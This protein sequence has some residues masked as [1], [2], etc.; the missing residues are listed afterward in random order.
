[1]QKKRKVLL[2]VG[3]LLMTFFFSF[4]LLNPSITGFIIYE[5]Q[6]DGSTINDTYLREQF[7]NNNFGTAEDLR[8]GNTS[9][10]TN[11]NTLI[12]DSNIST[13]DSE[14]TIVSAKLQI[15]ITDSFGNSNITLRA[16]QATS[17]WTES[18]A[19]WNNKTDSSTWT[20]PGGDYTTELGSVEITNQTGLYYNI[21]ITQAVREWVNTT[22]PNYGII[23]A[24][25]NTIAGNY[26]YF[27]SSEGTTPNQRPK[28]IIE[29]TQNAKP[30]I[31]NIST[32]STQ[33]SPIQIG[34]TILFTVNWTDLESNQAQIFIC[35]SSNITTAGCQDTTYCST[36]MEGTGPSSCVYK[37]L[38]TDN[39]TTTY[40]AATCD[41]S[42]CST[43]SQDTFYVNH[44]PTVSITQPDG[45]ETINQSQGNYTISFTVIDPNSDKLT[46]NI[47]YG[48]TQN[49]TTNTIVLN[50]NLTSTCTDA[51]SD[52]A[53]ENTCS[54]EWDS[55]NIHGTYFLTIGLNDSYTITNDSSSTSFE[56]RSLIDTTA[57]QITSQSIDSDIYSGESIQITADITESYLDTA[58]AKVNTTPQTNITLTNST[59][60]SY[61]GTWTATSPG[62]YQFKVYANDTIGNLNDSMSWQIFSIREPVATAQNEYAPSIALPYHTIKVTGELNATDSLSSVYA[63][64]NTPSGF[65]FLSDYPQN[66]LIGDFTASQIKNATWFLSVP[67]TE[68][69]Y[70]LNITY[71]D[72]YSNSWDSSNTQIQVTSAVGGGYLISS[73]G[74][75]EVETSYDYLI[76]GYFTQSGTRVAADSV[77]L[78][79]YDSTDSL[80]VGPASMSNPETGVYNYTYTVPGAPNEGQWQTIINAT[81]GSTSY[82]TNHFW[83]V[84]GGPFD[85]RD[86]TVL[87]SS[88]SNLNI[89]FVAENTGGANKDLIMTWNLS[90]VDNDSLLDSGGE[91][92]MVESA[93][94]KTWYINP[95]TAYVGQVKVTILGYYSGTEKA[96]A[97]HTFSTT[98]GGD[99]EYCGDTTCNNGETCTSCQADCGACPADD[100]PSGGG[101]GGSGGGGETQ[102]TNLTTTK[103]IQIELD[104]ETIVYL[105]KNIQKTM[106]LRITNPGDTKITN[107]EISL[108]GLSPS[109]YQISPVK[110]AQLNPKETKE[111]E[112]TLIMSE[113][114][115][116]L[117]FSYI[118]KSNNKTIKSQN[119]KIIMLG[120]IEYFLRELGRLKEKI[121]SI[122]EKTQNTKIL[123][124]LN[125]CENITNSLK[126]DI[127]NQ[128][129]INAIDNIK[130]ADECINEIENKLRIEDLN[131][132]K[133]SLLSTMPPNTTTVIIIAAIIILAILLLTL[134]ILYKIYRKLSK[135]N[136]IQSIEELKV[137]PKTKEEDIK[138]QDFSEKIKKIEDKISK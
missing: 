93:S 48:T 99:A 45:G 112:I 105:T 49:S 73:A 20:T 87:N 117:N 37:T 31:S 44:N 62:S 94:E 46:A 60:T 61:S 89:S 115:S 15:Y 6:S 70:D 118:I 79:I 71:T 97:F 96:G 41:T 10:E 104:A 129:F 130:K 92:F 28:I 120:T 16:Y 74:Y 82:Y 102:T 136:V 84:V 75:P 3:F 103:K 14:N 29:Y 67:L 12:L 68:N 42:N 98:Q 77:T 11:F 33:I 125:I 22:S 110:I 58:W 132:K 17:S 57:P 1:M 38:T 123:T 36:S 122:R 111:I 116:D 19:T 25:P 134:F 106:F 23:I 55:T 7:P 39:K 35:N 114:T 54:Y 113:L 76:E 137:P 78:S 4:F 52:T 64:L 59:P 107:L 100:S 80:I 85:V 121:F 108:E 63:Y 21:T 65:T 5:S 81:K 24:A 86:I 72:A 40:Y 9:G 95:S 47:Y 127:E 119:A 90:R 50:L 83:K 124:E 138:D 69:T 126:E 27:A 26:T 101:G 91:T 43:T 88:T 30:T 135:L 8:A 34:D 109:T 18:Q 66:V 128:E 133:D 53:T 32:N 13:I 2:T 51:D 131:S 56:V